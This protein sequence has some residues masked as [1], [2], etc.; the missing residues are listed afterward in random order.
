M[1]FFHN[2]KLPNLN[3]ILRID[4]KILKKLGQNKPFIDYKPIENYGII[5]N[6]E[7]AA[8]IAN[9]GSID[10]M[11]LPHLESES[12]FATLLDKDKGGFFRLSPR[13]AFTSSQEYEGD[14]NILKTKF[15]CFSG[16]GEITDFMP[17][18]KKSK[19]WHKQQVLF[20]RVKCNKGYVPW[21]L[22]FQPR[23]KYASRKPKII[24]IDTG[25]L[26]YHNQEQIYLDAP[27]PFKVSQLTAEANF[28][29]SEN[30]EIWIVM[31]YGVRNHFTVKDMEQK[32]EETRLFWEN[33]NHKCDLKQCVFSGPWHNLVIRSGLVLKL[34]THGETGAIAAAVT[35]SLPEKI[36][37]VRNW[38]YRFN[39]LRDSV[40][41]VQSLYNLGNKK[42][43]KS[44]F[45]WYK[46][47]YKGVKIRDIH[48]VY[49]LHGEKELKEK[50]LK[51]LSGYKNSKPVRIGN[52]AGNQTQLDVYGEILNVAFETSRY[53]ESLSKNDWKFLKKIVNHVCKIWDTKDSGI[54]EARSKKKHYVYSKLM[55]WV[56]IDRG[57]KIAEK[58]QFKAPTLKWEKIR[59]EIRQSIIKNG[60]DKELGSFVQSYNTKALD[61]AN[62]LIPIVGFLPFNDPRIEGTINAT[63]KYLTK[64]NFVFR[65]TSKDGLPGKEGAFTLCTFWLVDCLTLSGQIQKAEKI[66]INLLK[67]ISPLGLFAEEIEPMQ[68]T[69]LGNFPQA[70]SHVGLINS[71]LYIGLSK[72]KKMPGPKPLGIIGNK[73]I[74]LL[75]LR[76]ILNNNQ[77]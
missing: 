55:C 2:V 37:G 27:L 38:D 71:A 49:G 44:L 4:K 45:N 34:L 50:T 75:R 7:T 10:W 76:Y 28:T 3:N 35:T 41:T 24:N 69:M 65:Y 64:N 73:I 13:Y 70:L 17:L 39:W 51:H 14:T 77:N 29:L 54:W 23:F 67:H 31:Q 53:G 25:V 52:L 21:R 46:K 68:K 1:D 61:A 20:R 6:M 18:F 63:L 32:F 26:A 58:K 22:V 43:A 5:G 42:E 15:E 11:C 30:E 36:G 40:F 19:R 60:Y 74:S 9:D 48:I 66:F 12:V 8:L 72:G 62:L 56:A 16:N 59:D 47:L 33:W 57:L